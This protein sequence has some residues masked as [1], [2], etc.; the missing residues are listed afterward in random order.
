MTVDLAAPS[1]SANKQA[2]KRLS[3]RFFVCIY[4]SI[5]H[6]DFD[7]IRHVQTLPDSLE[8]HIRHVVGRDRTLM[9]REFDGLDSVSSLLLLT[10]KK[11][12]R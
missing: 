6:R 3:G 9:T 2:N 4:Q 5:R 10:C 7:W 11:S 1:V 12:T 8:I